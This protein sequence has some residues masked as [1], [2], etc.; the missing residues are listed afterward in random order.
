LKRIERL[1]LDDAR[2]LIAGATTK[3]EEL[4]IPMC[5]AVVDESGFLIAFERMEGGKP[6]STHLAQDKAFTAAVSFKTTADYNEICVPGNLTNGI[7]GT[8]GGRFTTVGGG[9][10]IKMEGVVVG[11]IGLSGGKPEQDIECA[12]AGIASLFAAMKG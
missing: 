3:A 12:E 10:P 6:L 1:D 4:G 8:L 5:I 9:I 7:N 11:A 2:Q